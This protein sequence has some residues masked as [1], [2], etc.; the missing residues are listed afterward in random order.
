MYAYACFFLWK[1]RKGN[2]KIEKKLKYANM[3]YKE[4]CVLGK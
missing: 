1:P 4:V 2:A 3:A